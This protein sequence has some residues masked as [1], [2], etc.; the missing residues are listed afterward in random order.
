[1]TVQKAETK[2]TKAQ[3]VIHHRF[4]HVRR[5]DKLVEAIDS[6]IPQA[7]TIL[8]VGCGDGLLAYNLSRCSGGR[9]LTG[10]EIQ[11]RDGCLI[12]CTAFDGKTIPCAQGAFDYVMFVDVLH[13]TANAEHLLREAVRVAR[14]GIVIKDHYCES[15]FDF[16]TL[17]FM[18]W[19]S[20]STKGVAIPRLYKAGAA[21]DAM[22]A[23]VGLRPVRT[24]VDLGLYPDPFNMIFGRKLH[25]VGLLEKTPSN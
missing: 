22:F 8:D 1:M 18:D 23:G 5:V 3:R 10:I 13:H 6:L 7:A 4:T 17:S 9:E 24:V 15:G 11:P 2:L 12:P 25:F 16:Y 19:F 20:N 14:H 21:W